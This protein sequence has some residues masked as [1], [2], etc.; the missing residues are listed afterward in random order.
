MSTK[1]R[2]LVKLHCHFFPAFGS[3]KD[4]SWQS[5][6]KQ[7]VASPRS[8]GERAIMLLLESFAEMADASLQFETPIGHDYVIK[9]HAKALL[10][11]ARAYLNFDIGRLD[12]GTLDRLIVELARINEVGIDQ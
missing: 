7:A 5:Q 4:F 12:A 8:G 9:D 3:T 11:A 6:H 2:N 10:E 1:N